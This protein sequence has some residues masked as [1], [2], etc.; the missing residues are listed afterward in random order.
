VDGDRER[1]GESAGGDEAD[2]KAGE[3]CGPSP[4]G[5][6]REVGHRGASALDYFFDHRGERFGVLAG[7][8]VRRRAQAR[9]S[10]QERD[11]GTV[12]GVQAKEHRSSV[13]RSAGSA[14]S[15]GSVGERAEVHALPPGTDGGDLGVPAGVIRP[16]GAYDGDLETVLREVLHEPLA[17]FDDGD[18]VGEVRI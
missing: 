14:G 4:Y 18:R 16:A 12:G 13:V 8:L 9:V 5:D 2:P 17:P 10:L 1:E 15:A 11:G 6:A 3:R 7:V